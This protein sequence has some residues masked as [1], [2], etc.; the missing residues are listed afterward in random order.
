[1]IFSTS[2][3]FVFFAVPKTG[4]HAVRELTKLG[5]GGALENIGVTTAE[6]A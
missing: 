5:L 2:R 3:Q 1:M 6:L 4:T